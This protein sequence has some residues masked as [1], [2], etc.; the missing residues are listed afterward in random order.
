MIVKINVATIIILCIGSALFAIGAFMFFFN[1]FDTVGLLSI[2]EG[3]RRILIDP[4]E[5][6]LALLIIGIILIPI[7][8]LVNRFRIVRR[9]KGD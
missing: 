4:Y 7:A 9:Q 5:T 3:A 1:I 2:G 8:L 6:G